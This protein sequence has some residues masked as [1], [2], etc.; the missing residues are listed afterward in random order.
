MS[1]EQ[2]HR[3][4]FAA[5]PAGY[6][7]SVR[8]TASGS[9]PHEG[10]RG[11]PAPTQWLGALPPSH[12]STDWSMDDRLAKNDRST[13]VGR[14]GRVGRLHPAVAGAQGGRPA[15]APA[16]LVRRQDRPQPGPAGRRLGRLRPPRGLL[17]AAGHRRLPGGGVHPARLPRPRRRPP[18]DLPFP[19][20]QRPGRP[21][22]R[23]P[24]GRGELRLVGRQA[25][26]PPHQPQPRGPG[27]RH[28]HRRA[29]VH[30]RARPAPGT[31]WSGWSPATRPGCSS[32]CCCWRRPTC[33]WPASRPSSDGRGRG[34]TWS[35][36]CCC[37]P[38]SPAT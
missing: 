21:P 5:V 2:R 4:C 10:P 23:Q 33:T 38:M 14:Q 3:L 1:P 12:C 20:R 18:P 15:G 25:Q 19:A 17:V 28:Q 6:P 26:P 27:P 37:A 35:R 30:R 31:G 11:A 9:V 36:G 13:G 16:R 34:P 29:R 32:R 7:P 22:P 8:G 24:A